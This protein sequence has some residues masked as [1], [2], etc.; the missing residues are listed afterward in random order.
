MRILQVTPGFY[1]EV[2]GVQAHVQ[3][4]AEKLVARG[5]E[6]HV[7]A[8]AHRGAGPARESVNGVQV[9]R[10][11]GIGP[12]ESYRLPSGLVGYLLRAQRDFDIIH[13][14]NYHAALIPVVA[15]VT[16]QALVITP[17][18]NDQPHSALARFLHR[19]YALIGRWGMRRAQAVICVSDAERERV[20]ARLGV[21][22]RKTVVIPNGVDDG[23]LT[24]PGAALSRDPHLLLS[25]GRLEPYKRIEDSIAALAV[26]PA[27][28]R[29]V[30]VGRGPHR[31]GLEQVAQDQGV[32][33][34]VTFAGY[35]LKEALPDRYRRAQV[36]LN[37]ST[38]E[39]FGMTVLEAVAGGCRAVCRDIPAFRDL[40]RQ[41]PAYVT[42][43]ADGRPETIAA[44]VQR[45]A[46]RPD[47]PPADLTNFTWSR[48]AAETEKLYLRC[49]HGDAGV[50]W[51]HTTPEREQ[52]H[53]G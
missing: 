50:C 43:I 22:H 18:L 28:Y 52:G 44:A 17:H 24:G 3:A 20:A 4:I 10:F 40:A 29:L 32:S 9:R 6:V 35:V 47:D 7:A 25:V 37:L 15:A 42:T 45:A 5:H 39:A 23:V 11:I 2:G 19:P 30:I 41:F 34:R 13:V 48:I 36:A 14:H 27:E 21:A 49:L 12:G 38:A 16:R 46:E 26:L 33:D 51:A 1:P 53:A 31:E 8:M